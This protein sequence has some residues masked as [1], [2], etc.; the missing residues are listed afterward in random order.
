VSAP[1]GQNSVPLPWNQEGP[2]L[3]LPPPWTV[4]AGKPAGPPSGGLSLRH[5]ECPGFLEM[6]RAPGM[7][8]PRRRGMVVAAAI[9]A[10][11]FIGL[12]RTFSDCTSYAFELQAYDVVDDISREVIPCG[13][14]RCIAAKAA[15]GS[16][17]LLAFVGSSTCTYGSLICRRVA[18]GISDSSLSA[19][20]RE[21]GDAESLRALAQR[22]SL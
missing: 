7:A 15:N 2:R 18:I 9:V 13:R 12:E 1:K 5:P 17:A 4:E 14:L 20:P 19:V 21:A 6:R 8:C 11:T 10:T 22:R 3:P 16:W